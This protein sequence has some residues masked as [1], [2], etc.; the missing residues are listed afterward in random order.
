[1]TPKLTQLANLI[2]LAK[3]DGKLE[4]EEIM[5]IYGIAER[6]SVSKF[7]LDEVIERADSIETNAP[8]DPAEA[9][10][11]LYQLMVMAAIDFEVTP[12]ETALLHK[13]GSELGLE[14]GKVD[15]AIEYLIKNQKTD[16]NDDQVAALF[17]S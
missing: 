16:L 15:Q 9:I 10:R 12:G 4:Q 6:N 3:A 14:S 8:S 17:G 7:E 5:L 1:M 11:F 2:K 13:V